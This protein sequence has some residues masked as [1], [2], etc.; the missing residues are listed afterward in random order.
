[1]HEEVAE[2]RVILN[3]AGYLVLHLSFGYSGI[4]FKSLEG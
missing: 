1:M 3:L 2:V 4:Y